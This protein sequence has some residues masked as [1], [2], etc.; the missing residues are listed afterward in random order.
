MSR[1]NPHHDSAPILAAA[2]RWAAN[3]LAD[4]GSV[5]AEGE[6]LWTSE[7]LD[8][9]DRAFVQNYDEGE[10]NFLEKLEKQLASATP[11]ARKLMAE[12]LWALMLFQAN[13][14]ADRKRANVRTVWGWSGDELHPGNP[15]LTDGVLGGLGSAGTAY[16]TLRWRELSFLLTGVRAFK[17]KPA[18]ERRALLDDATGFA[19]WIRSLPDA[20]NRQF[21][22][23]C[24]LL[25]FPD[26]FERI[27]SSADKRS[28]LAAFTGEREKDLKRWDDE[29]IDRELLALRRRLETERS[30][31]PIDFYDADLASRWRGAPRAWLL[32]WNPENWAWDTLAADRAA[33]ARGAPVVMPWRCASSKPKEGDAAYLMRTGVAP[34]GIVAAGTIVKAPFEGPHYD[35]ARANAGEIASFVEVQFS[36]IRDAARD[37]IV[38]RETLAEHLPNQEWSP[39]GS[40]IQ[41]DPAAALALAELWNALPSITADPAAE[42]VEDAPAPPAA[43][44]QSAA[45]NIILYGPP[46]TGKTHRLQSVLMPG[47]EERTAAGAVTR[48]FEFVTFHQNYSY[49]DFMEGIRLQERR[50]LLYCE[51]R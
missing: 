2:A 46:G 24:L 51:R 43:P 31:A 3:C 5:L 19:T 17:L 29:R 42:D 18:S 21:R 20:K 25:L 39:Q 26:E 47:Y 48:R 50:H 37:E 34:R 1:H 41:I 45:R 7:Q 9:L 28:I 38:S 16:N 6:R 40:G 23:I 33:A 13:V 4:D 36:G 14:G 8:E 44:R 30:G 49:E 15:M 22:H 32:S 35:P 10:G 12:A 11:A 27:S